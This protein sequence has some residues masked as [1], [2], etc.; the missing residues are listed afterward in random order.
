MVAPEV[1]V[2]DHGICPL[3]QQQMVSKEEP[4]ATDSEFASI[5]AAQPLPLTSVLAAEPLD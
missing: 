1:E 4:L 2:V 3:C 5:A